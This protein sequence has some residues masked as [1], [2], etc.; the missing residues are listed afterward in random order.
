[1]NSYNLY[2]LLE[3]TASQFN[4]TYRFNDDVLSVNN[5]DFPENYLGQMYPAEL[6]IKGMMESKTSASYLDWEGRSA[7]HFPLRQT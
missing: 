4:F 3:K 5:P 1:M 6:E 2:S 7:A